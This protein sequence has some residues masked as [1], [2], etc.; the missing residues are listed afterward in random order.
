MHRTSS[1]CSPCRGDCFQQRECPRVVPQKD[2]IGRGEVALYVAGF[3]A[4]LLVSHFWPGLW[5]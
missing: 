3:V 2:T 5:F 1:H 4:T